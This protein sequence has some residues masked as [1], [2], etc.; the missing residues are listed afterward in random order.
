VKAT[1]N[2]LK[3]YD[4]IIVGG[5]P[6]GMSA[7][8]ILARC[9]RSILIFDTGRQRNLLAQEM[10]GY[11]TRDGIAPADFLELAR[12]ELRSYDVEIQKIAI[13]KAKKNDDHFLLTDRNGN[14]YKCRKLLLATGLLDR[15]PEIEGIMDFYGKSVHHCPYCDGW[16]ERDKRVVV[17]GR[18]KA[19]YALSTTLLNWT[20]HVILCSDGGQ[21]PRPHL[22]AELQ[23]RGVEIHTGRIQK[24][25]GTDGRL[26]KI[27]LKNGY[28]VRCEAMFFTN[29]YLQHSLLGRILNCRYNLK[30]EI[31]VNHVQES[32]IEGLYV[33]G[34]AAYE[35]KLVII[36]AGEGAKA[37]VAINVRL[38]EEDCIAQ[39]GR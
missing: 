37:G 22:M 9:R 17:Y 39:T 16:E 18:G 7:A 6:A 23:N 38:I 27:H 21:K 4:V 8:L 1:D 29:G 28:V 36:A 10:H 30:N 19:G 32:N 33:S 31:Y 11:L 34:D 15:I 20:K 26:E 35:M 12:E 24:L 25:T 5:G 14:T 13:D 2:N 3:R